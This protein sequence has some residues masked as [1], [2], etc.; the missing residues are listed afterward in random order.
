M[1]QG[2]GGG[3]RGGRGKRGGQSQ[4]SL[5]RDVQ[6][7]K[8]ISWLLRHGAQKEGLHL[9]KAGFVNVAELLNH[10]TFRS[11]KVT[12]SEVRDVVETNDKQRFTMAPILQD[13]QQDDVG[14][15]IEPSEAVSEDPKDYLIRAN[16]GHSLKIESEGLLQAITQD[17]LPQMAVHGTTRSAW[18]LIVASG[19]LKPMGRNHVHFATGLPSGFKSVVDQDQP[20]VEAPVI[21]GMRNSSSI[22]VYL[23]IRKAMESG[24]KLWISDNNVILTEGNEQGLV[25]LE[26]F[27]RVEDRSGEGVL[28]E[29]GQIIKTAPSHWVR[30]A[31]GRG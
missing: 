21:S 23:D 2:G 1:G 31:K 14:V 26:Y 5:S 24:M 8:K 12:F 11:M 18:T 17:N 29:N 10:H 6:I 16:Q 28:V 13:S 22:L 25:P 3:A 19:G 27:E 30:K 15:T 7:S 9:D 4:Q 20:N